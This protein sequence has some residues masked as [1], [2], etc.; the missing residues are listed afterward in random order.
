MGRGR[1]AWRAGAQGRGRGQLGDLLPGQ[2]ARGQPNQ[3]YPVNQR[4][5]RTGAADRV[6]VDMQPK[7]VVVQTGN[8]LG[9]M[10]LS[11]IV[12]SPSAQ[13]R[14]RRTR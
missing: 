3:L 5:A 8:R 7:D 10:M 13:Q 11:A 14:T 6:D 4:A 2:L 9:L 1:S 12:T